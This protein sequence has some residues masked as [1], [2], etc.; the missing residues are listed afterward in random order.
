MSNY[1]KVGYLEK[2]D[3]LVNFPKLEQCEKHPI[4]VSECVQEIPCN[5][6][7]SA[8]AVKAISMD[9][10][11]GIPMIDYE[12]CTGCGMC[13]SVCPGLALFLIHQGENGYEVTL[14]YEMLPLPKVGDEVLLLNRKGE[15]LGK[16]KVK[17]VLRVERETQSTVITVSFEDE[18]FIYEVRNIEVQNG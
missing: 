15:N 3:I 6:C 8:C 1:L 10:I 16:G 7:V 13:V 5:P 4:A 18:S 9:G 2:D 11:N 14:P 12:K 17:R